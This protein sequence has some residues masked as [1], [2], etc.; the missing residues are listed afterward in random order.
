M[1]LSGSLWYF[2]TCGRDDGLVM[3]SG[4]RFDHSGAMVDS[5]G[6][7]TCYGC[8]TGESSQSTA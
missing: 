2:T 5:S 6:C 3:S 4:W 8:T 1:H 7:L